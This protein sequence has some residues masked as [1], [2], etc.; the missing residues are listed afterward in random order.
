M[1]VSTLIDFLM[2]LLRDE[3]ARAAFEQDPQGELTRNGLDCVSAQDVRDARLIMADDGGVRPRSEGGSSSNHSDPVREIHH[4]TNNYEINQGHTVGDID[5]TLNVINID[6]RDTVVVDSF[7][8]ADTNDIDVV[9]IQDNSTDIDIEDSFNEN[10]PEP[11]PTDEVSTDP[12]EEP[13]AGDAPAEP[14]IGID[15]VE[16]AP[17]DEGFGPEPEVSIDPV[18][19]EPVDEPELE[20]AIV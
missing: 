3:D 2:N 6:D 7:N 9:A 14:E 17:V 16:S 13:A 18:E 10:G 5:Q 8:S 11:E 1:S 19:S 15:P 12:V 20:T 4:T